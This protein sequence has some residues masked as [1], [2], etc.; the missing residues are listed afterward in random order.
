MSTSLVKELREKTGAG[1]MECKRALD[2]ANGNIEKAVELL[3]QQGIAKA[4]KKA[5][6]ATK[7]GMVAT[8]I[9]AGGRIG[10]MVEVNCETDFVARTDEFKA[11][12]HDLAMQV[13]AMNPR[14]V[15]ENEITPEARKAGIAQ[16]GSE[17]S[18][19]E[20][21]VLLAQAFIKD[22]RRTMGD[23]VQDAVA[24]MGENIVVRRAVRFEV[25]ETPG[26]APADE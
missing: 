24:K 5:G 23:L 20:G 25:G 3:R 15:S 21:D 26:D 1:V 7:Q 2:E 22:S 4:G 19:L 6:R 10:G 16:F 14:Y 11:L 9:H 17:K 18:F 8:Y 12:A 13:V